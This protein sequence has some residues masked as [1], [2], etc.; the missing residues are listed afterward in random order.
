MKR[1]LTFLLTVALV[2]TGFPIMPASK[3]YGAERHWADQYLNNLVRNDIMQGDLQGNLNPDNNI[4]RAEFVAM[5]N[6]AFGYVQ[7][8]KGNFSDV[9]KGAWYSD[10]INIAKNQGYMQGTDGNKAEPEKSLTREQAVT[11]ICRALKIEGINADTFKFGDSREFSQW[12]KEYINAVTN[13]SI[14]NGYPDS[15]FRPANNMTRGEMAKVLSNLAGEIIKDSGNNYIGYADKNVSMVKSG[16]NLRDTIIPGDLFL[17]AGL[18]KGYS[19]LDQVTVNGDLIVSGT[20]NSEKG[21]VSVLLKDSDIKHLIIDSQS[22]DIMSVRAEGG[23]VI[24]KT[25]VKRNAYLEE[26]SDKNI[27]FK[28]VEL[29]G[30]SGTKL[31]MSGNFENVKV[32]APN[33]QLSLSKGYISVLTVD[34]EAEKGSIFLE[35]STKVGALMIDTA[36]TVTGSGEVEEIVINA[37]GSNISM[38]PKRIYIRPGIKAIVNGKTMTSLDGDANNA[39]PEFKADYPKLMD[40]QSTSAKLLV[41]VNKPGKFYWAVKDMGAAKPGA[42]KDDLVQPD[43]RYFLKSGNQ[44]L[45]GEKETTI[46]ISGLKSGGEYEY[47]AMFEDLKGNRTSIRSERFKTVD[48]IAPQFLGGTPSITDKTNSSF[49]FDVMPSKDGTIYWAVYKNRAVPPTAEALAEQK[50]S[51]ALGKGE[52]S[53]NVNVTRSVMVSGNAEGP[54]NENENYDVY[55]VI[56]DKAGNLSRLSKTVGTTL[57]TTPPIFEIEP[58]NEPGAKTA[59]TVNTMINEGGTIF[60]AAYPMDEKYPQMDNAELQMRTITTGDRAHRNGQKPTRGKVNEKIV[61]NG[62]EATKPYDIY[63]LAKDKAQ[64]TSVV[65]VLKGVKTLDKT[66]PKAEMVFDNIVSG[67]PLINSRI[68]IQFDEI[69]YYDDV[70]GKPD[71]RLVELNDKYSARK[72]QILKDMLLLHD[73]KKVTQPDYYTAIDYSKAVVDESEGKTYVEFPPEAFGDTKGLNSGGRYQFELRKVIDSDGNRMDYGAKMKPFNIIAPQIGLQTYDG[74]LDDDNI[75]F[76]ARKI[77]TINSDQYYDV[78]ISSDR[79]IVFDLYEKKAG[80]SESKIAENI[81]IEANQ[82]KSV[83]QMAK[84]TGFAKFGEIKDT[85][86]RLHVKSLDAIKTLDSWDGELNLQSTIIVGNNADLRNMS[87]SI[88]NKAN[89]MSMIEKNQA[90]QQVS[91]PKVFTATRTYADIAPPKVKGAI[92]FEVFDTTA[93]ATV[94]TDK[95]ADIYY[96]IVPLK[97]FKDKGKEVP[98]VDQVLTAQPNYIE[99]KTGRISFTSGNVERQEFIKD[100]K[101]DTYYKF[102]YVIKGKG[103]D[104]L[105][106]RDKYYTDTNQVAVNPDKEDFKTE[107]SIEP[108]IIKDKNI[109]QLM[110]TGAGTKETAEVAASANIEATVY[111]VAFL[112]GTMSPSVDEVIGM[113]DDNLVKTDSGNFAITLASDLDKVKKGIQFEFNVKNLNPR[114]GYDVFIALKNENSGAKS[115]EVYKLPMLRSFD[116]DPPT[117]LEEPQ[118]TRLV[119]HKE[120]DGSYTYDVNVIAKFT[121]PLYYRSTSSATALEPL[122][123]DNLFTSTSKRGLFAP[124]SPNGHLQ[125]PNYIDAAGTANWETDTEAIVNIELDLQG[126]KANSQIGFVYDIYSVSG[127]YAGR[128]VMTFKE[129]PPIVEEVDKIVDGK[130]VKVKETRPAATGHF[131]VEFIR[132]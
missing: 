15:T 94:M 131:E 71:I 116:S 9:D 124:K 56:R 103:N 86:Y 75:G 91:N 123:F 35:K 47:Y 70:S 96:V 44:V 28:D 83:T 34:E 107:P 66:P 105:E 64:N 38:L 51:G 41:T 110:A 32:M 85:D 22:S 67:E 126:V 60:W 46:N 129:D 48:V 5:I 42:S 101:P 81:R 76:S 25:T 11:L 104:N 1:I 26:D 16:A 20:G 100:L 30:V 62:L 8:G 21:Q 3:S 109:L 73:L 49:K 117:L 114:N 97:A 79:L 122:K 14:V 12:S 113:K 132:K 119:A 65:K 111:W 19:L 39:D 61:I 29:K 31:N 74:S 118:T 95:P 121:K 80:E 68:K 7:K 53:A 87:N 115:P 69:V 13:K 92:S 98:T 78:I 72:V 40:V 50:V 102:F 36:T 108:I 89:T 127:A 106:V 45:V 77:D 37:D 4:T 88:I 128:L 27:A 90:V 17:T 43:K 63:F 112:S 23:S 120:L 99:G 52:L 10:E 84:R 2:L 33:N 6:R 59:I 82:G 125:I 58:W 18:G 24:E 54:L 130:V 93:Y 57:D 55:F